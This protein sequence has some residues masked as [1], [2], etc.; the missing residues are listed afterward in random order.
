M[1]GLLG[2]T[3]GMITTFHEISGKG[4]GGSSQLGLAQGRVR[5]AALHGLR[6]RHRHSGPDLLL[7]S[8]AGR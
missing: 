8:S 7:P 4:A 5:G 3:L 6:P 2:T 1:L